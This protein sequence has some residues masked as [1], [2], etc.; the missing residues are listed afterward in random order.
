[1]RTDLL[2]AA[3]NVILARELEPTC[4][5]KLLG[6]SD[7]QRFLSDEEV[8]D[9]LG[10]TDAI[11]LEAEAAVGEVGLLASPHA[12]WIATA[13]HQLTTLRAFAQGL[14]EYLLP[15]EGTDASNETR[16]ASSRLALLLEDDRPAVSAAAGLWQSCIRAREVDPTRAKSVLRLALAR[17]RPGTLPFALFA[18]L[19]RCRI[20]ASQDGYA[21]ALA[22]LTQLE[23]HADSW[24]DTDA[25]RANALRTIT[26]VEIQVLS[27][28][29]ARLSGPPDSTQR[30]WCTDRIST[31][32]DER[33]SEGGRSVFRLTTAIPIIVTP[34]D[35]HRRKPEARQGNE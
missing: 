14:Q 30:R 8:G 13:T 21:A 16:P 18:R 4:S 15:R 5:A 29:Q 3:A 24:L 1:M 25:D 27:D 6:F 17:P 20:L 19:L 12:E 7:D 2:L 33:F 31:L 22:L 11:L 35:A 34:E 10:R 32:V 26:L 28:W 9:A 23:D